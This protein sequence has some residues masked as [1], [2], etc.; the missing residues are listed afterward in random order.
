M[1]TTMPLCATTPTAP[2]CR[3]LLPHLRFRWLRF[4]LQL[5]QLGMYCGQWPEW[6]QYCTQSCNGVV[7]HPLGS[8]LQRTCSTCSI[9]QLFE[10]FSNARRKGAAALVQFL[11]GEDGVDVLQTGFLTKFGFQ[12]SNADRFAQQLR[13][14]EAQAAAGAM[15]VQQ[16]EAA[17]QRAARWLAAAHTAAS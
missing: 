16:Q 17:L 11:Y 1:C 12:A 3:C 9:Q 2:S 14:Q 4:H 7:A 6:L 8:W 15:A 13:L 10:D 5:Q